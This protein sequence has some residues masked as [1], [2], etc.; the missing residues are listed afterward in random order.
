MAQSSYVVRLFN[1]V[2]QVV[3]KVILSIGKCRKEHQGLHAV[4]RN[5]AISQDPWTNEPNIE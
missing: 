4:V 2:N 1:R 3:P 5:Y